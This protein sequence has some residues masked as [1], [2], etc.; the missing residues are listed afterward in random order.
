MPRARCLALPSIVLA[1]CALGM[2]EA[3]AQTV[4]VSRVHDPCLIR[5]GDTYYLFHTGRGVPMKTSRDLLSWDDAG[6]VF[7]DGMPD[8]AKAEI[9]GARTLWAPDISFFEGEYHLYYS[10]STFGSQRSCIGLAT[11]RTLDPASPD[12][13]WV[14]R[15]KVIDSRPVRDDFNAIDPNVVIDD[16]GTPWMSLGSFWGGIKLVKLDPRTGKPP[17]DAK[18]RPLARRPP[19]DAIEAPFIVRKGDFYYLFVSFDY[20]CK[21]ARSDYHIVVGRSKDVT[22]P[23]VDRD[24]APMLEGGGTV[25]LEGQGSLRGPGHNAVLLRPEGDLLVHHFY[26]ADAA[27]LVKM[28]VRSLA[29]DDDGWPV[30][31]DLVGK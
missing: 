13:K 2:G 26:D 6:R 7:A 28:Q 12:Y 27:G 16:K 1:L 21:G 20:C 19:P 11:N 9:P 18:V 3:L 17:E 25:V 14:D 30:A 15:G 5:Q 22:G 29:W 31:G 10:V 24:G 4:G 23:Y 8:W